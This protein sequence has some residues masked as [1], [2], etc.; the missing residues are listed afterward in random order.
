MIAIVPK[1]KLI[2]SGSN[3]MRFKG[4]KG[5][6]LQ[7]MSIQNRTDIVETTYAPERARRVIWDDN[8]P[9]IACE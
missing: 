4:V 3:E 6:Y 9:R 2:D 8:F 7:N 1:S 5:M